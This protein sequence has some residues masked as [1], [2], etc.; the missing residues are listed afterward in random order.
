MSLPLGALAE[1]IPT[2]RYNQPPLPFPRSGA[3]STA[4]RGLDVAMNY[5]SDGRSVGWRMHESFSF[6]RGES[7][8]EIRYYGA[9]LFETVR[10]SNPVAGTNTDRWELK[11]WSDQNGQP[12]VELYGELVEFD[13]VARSKEGKSEWRGVE[14]QRYAFAWEL[15]EPFEAE[16]GKSYWFSVLS[17]ADEFEPMFVVVAGHKGEAGRGAPEDPAVLGSALAASSCLQRNLNENNLYTRAGDQALA[18]LSVPVNDSDV[19]GMDDAWEEAHGLDPEVDESMSDPDEDGL[20]CLEEFERQTHPNLADTDG[21]GLGDAVETN[22]GIFASATDRGTSPLLADTDGDGI[23]DADEDPTLPYSA[24]G[25]AGTDPNLADS[26]GDSLS[27]LQELESLTNPTLRDS[28]ADGISDQWELD[29]FTDPNDPADPVAVTT[30]FPSG[31]A[32][33]QWNTT[34]TLASFNAYQGGLDLADVTFTASVDFEEKISGAP[35]IIFETGGGTIGFSLVYESGNRLILRA[36]GN[37]GFALDTIERVL[38]AAEIAGDQIALTWGYD[39]LDDS[40]KQSIGLWIDGALASEMSTDLGGDWSGGGDAA[41]GVYDSVQ[42][43]V[44]GTGTNNNLVSTDFVSGAIDLSEGLQMF[45]SRYPVVGAIDRMDSDGDG[46]GDY[47]ETRYGLDIDM[48][49]TTLDLDGDTLSNLDE[50]NRGTAPDRRDTDGDG[51]DDNVE[52]GK[53][54]WASASDTG[55]DPNNPDSDGD[56]FIDGVEDNTGTYVDADRTGT[57]PN[58][59]DSDG[60]ELPDGL[61]LRVGRDPTISDLPAP[62]SK[63]MQNFDGYPEGAT[64]LGDGTTIGSSDGTAQVLNDALRLTSSESESTR[65]SF[66][67]PALPGSS[68]GWT[69]TFDLTLRDAIDDSPPADGFTFSY[70]AIPPLV[71]NGSGPDGHGAAEVGHGTGNEISFQVD[72]WRNGNIDN[73]PGVGILQNGVALPG[74]RTNGPVLLNGASRTVP[75]SISWNPTD[76]T[77]TTSG[78]ATDATFENLPHSFIGDDSYSWVFSCR[79]GGATEDL[80]IDNLE[81]RTGSGAEDF[82]ILSVDTVV[83]PGEGG[84][85]DTISVTVTWSST[86]GR[87]YR[88]Y[89]S[90]D[91][92]TEIVNWEELDDSVPGAA[93][94]EQTSFTETGIPIDTAR[95]YYQVRHSTSN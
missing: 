57:D 13:G 43:S 70:G 85:P 44:A 3:L 15:A 64:S 82:R 6:S 41:L 56:R 24:G 45:H 87:S 36:S 52:T 22:R 35:E 12:G 89:A 19:D 8:R 16:A 17:V 77:F 50:I 33:S 74:G 94:L 88:V 67:I 71:S 48:D 20:S 31:G 95:R 90:P 62:S 47:Y 58:N 79:T 84:D 38:S 76:A 86:E 61:E 30:S 5:S 26:D 72:T 10:S 69:A 23:G 28:D 65:S 80:I 49:D 46:M 18:I 37:G 32:T 25:N 9:Y 34:G 60:D 21:D 2:L 14:L 91:L 39:V 59:L 75:V 83:V 53:G 4:Q 66:R 54:T 42:G 55:T 11:I 63:Y 78:L 29:H 1:P 40:G 27:D 51:L 73:P 81:I 93:G 68:T 92:P 7:I